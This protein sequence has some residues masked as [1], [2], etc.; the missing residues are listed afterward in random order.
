MP[1]P[2]RE[3]LAKRFL[4][5]A[6]QHYQ[7]RLIGLTAD[8]DNLLANSVGI[9]DHQYIDKALHDLIEKVAAERDNLETVRDYRKQRAL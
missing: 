7:S 2:T 8:V 9:D 1:L 4:D 3:E 5:G 6:E